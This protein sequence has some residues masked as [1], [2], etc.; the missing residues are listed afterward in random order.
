MNT[1]E[2]HAYGPAHL[3]VIGLTTTTP[4]LLAAVA[5]SRRTE[6]A[7]IAVITM[8]LVLNYAGYLFFIRAH[9]MMNWLQMLPL[10]M[11]DWGMAVVIIALWTARQRWFE[12][13]YFWGI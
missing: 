2:F 4:F 13:A 9:G 5:R 11:C 1:P 8:L 6:R 3:V 12:V 10:Q 7:I